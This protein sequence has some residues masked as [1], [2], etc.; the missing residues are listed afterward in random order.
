MDPENRSLKMGI[1]ALITA[2]VFRLLSAFLPAF[3][4]STEMA[5]VLLFLETGRVVKYSFPAA[6]SEPEPPPGIVFSQ[7]DAA[8]VKIS[9]ADKYGVDVQASLQQSLRWDLTA[10]EPAVLIFHSHA[11]ESYA[12][13]KEQG[14]RST[15]A[16]R[17]MLCIGAYLAQL[18]EE[19][20]IACIHDTTLHDKPSYNEAY[21]SSRKSIDA[22]L[23]QYP[24][25]RLVL[26]LH[27]DSAVDANGNHYAATVTTTYGKSAKL[28]LVMGTNAGGQH[29]QWQENVALG[30][31]LQAVLEKQNPGICRS[32][33]LRTSRFNQDLSTG[34]LLVEVGADGNTQQEA[35]NAVSAL[36]NAIFTLAYGS[37]V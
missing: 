3:P 19:G 15:D 28:M 17:N 18:L 10:D 37:S 23:E 1:A 5:S 36:A 11:T 2:L 20:G 4:I 6:D 33:V 13:T 22:Y 25:I 9:N 26:D 30:I 24:S 16:G 29:P 34:A 12:D 27:R 14:Y 35:L 31:K 21:S 8:L 7:E 32:M